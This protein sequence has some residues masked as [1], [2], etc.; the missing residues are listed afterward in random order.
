MSVAFL[1][2]NVGFSG[3]TT[4]GALSPQPVKQITNISAATQ[5]PPDERLHRM[6]KKVGKLFWLE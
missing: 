2:G 3:I 5:Q 1:G 4:F 6:E